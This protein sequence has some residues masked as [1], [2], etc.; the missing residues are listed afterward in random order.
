MVKKQ[1]N[2]NTKLRTDVKNEF[3]KEFF[4]LINNAV[5]GRMIQNVREHR[6]IKLVVTE[7]RRKKLTSE[8][9]LVTSTVFSENLEATEV[10]KT[11][12]L[13]NK[14]NAVGQAILDKSKELMYTFW[15]DLIKPMYG[16]KAPLCYMHADSFVILIQTEDFFKILLIQLMNGLILVN[17]IQ[18]VTDHC[19]QV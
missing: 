7:E 17:T 13:M 6:D 19:L 4:K 11:S 14:P 2:H 3:E 15:Y 12:I 1:I 18:M 8:P 10:R 9:N 5:F 16:E